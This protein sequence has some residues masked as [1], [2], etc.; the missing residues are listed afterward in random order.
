MGT[1]E[2]NY[3][4]RDRHKPERLVQSLRKPPAENGQ[5]CSSKDGCTAFSL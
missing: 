4:N 3:E 2:D 1:W 5:G